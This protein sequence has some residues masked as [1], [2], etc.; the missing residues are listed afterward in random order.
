[1]DVTKIFEWIVQNGGPSFVVVCALALYIHRGSEKKDVEV[2]EVRKENKELVL[3][4]I[5]DKEKRL[6]ADQENRGLIKS[7]IEKTGA[8]TATIR[9][10]FARMEESQRVM[11]EEIRQLKS[12]IK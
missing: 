2:V 9:E 1:M 4:L 10:S 11:A 6:I 8:T 7:L 12:S 5:N 3:Q